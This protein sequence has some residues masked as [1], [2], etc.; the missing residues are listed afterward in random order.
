MFK[1]INDERLKINSKVLA[2]V[3]I[4]RQSLITTEGSHRG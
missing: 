3:I 2:S 1:T 4:N